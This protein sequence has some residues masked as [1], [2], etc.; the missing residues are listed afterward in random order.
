MPA[1]ALRPV[2]SVTEIMV[3]IGYLEEGDYNVVMM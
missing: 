2:R 3:Q 1:G